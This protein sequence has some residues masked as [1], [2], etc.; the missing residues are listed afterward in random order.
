[1]DA[2]VQAVAGRVESALALVCDP[3]LRAAARRQA[4]ASTTRRQFG[5]AI[6]RLEAACAAL[7]QGLLLRP[8]AVASLLAM[9]A[10][11]SASML[12]LDSAITACCCFLEAPSCLRQVRRR[13]WWRSLRRRRIKKCRPLR[14]HGVFRH[15]TAGAAI[16]GLYFLCMSVVLLASKAAR[17]D[18]LFSFFSLALFSPARWPTQATLRRSCV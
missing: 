8:A 1:M 3:A 10:D 9:L 7:P 6:D 16:P 14:R 12:E 17:I 13:L 18:Q 5:K 2:T 11:E 4:G 15:Q